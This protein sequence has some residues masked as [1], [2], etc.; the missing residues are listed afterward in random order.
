MTERAADDDAGLLSRGYRAVSL[1]VSVHAR[2]ARREAESDLRR[3]ATGVALLAVA[4]GLVGAALVLGHV[5]AV[6]LVERRFGWGLAESV[7]AVAGADLL[8][9]LGLA[10]SARARLSAPV[11]AE[12]REVVRKAADVLRA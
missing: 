9:A 5:A 1:L 4:V 11:L 12:T 6:L 10:L 8:L 7:G 2:T 3:I